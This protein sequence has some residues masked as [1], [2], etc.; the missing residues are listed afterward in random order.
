M[1]AAA[2]LGILPPIVLPPILPPPAP[3]NA[4]GHRH[5][6]RHH[7]RSHHHHRAR[8]RIV[9]TGRR[10]E[11]IH[12]IPIT[13]RA[14]AAKRVAMSLRLPAGRPGRGVRAAGEVQVSTTCPPVRLPTCIGQPYDYNPV[15]TGRLVLAPNAH[16]ATGRSVAR[17]RV[18]CHQRAPNRNHHCVLAFAPRAF[19]LSGGRPRYVNL[20]IAAHNRHARARQLLV[21]GA[22]KP[23]GR[24]DQGQSRLGAIVLPRN[25]V[26]ATHLRSR[27]PE[28]RRLT[29][30]RVAHDRARV[31][32][33]IRVPHPQAGD[34]LLAKGTARLGIGRLSYNV[35]LRSRLTLATSP[36]AIAPGRAIAHHAILGGELA[37][38][39]GFNVTHGKSGYRT[40]SRATKAGVTALRGVPRTRSGHRRPLYVNFVSW[41]KPLL[42]RPD[43]GDAVR[44][45]GGGSLRAV[46]YR[47]R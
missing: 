32:Y 6:H 20:V 18:A 9:T 21:I 3:P 12:K 43:A 7:R 40:P 41:A 23:S 28:R 27:A 5:Q 10:S 34:R 24:I 14:G 1:L 33:S 19:A 15:V 46:R 25:G 39:N 35:Y 38:S 29:T 11:R 2:T 8:V 37:P 4:P 13:R 30:G 17:R 31:L 36:H 22:D 45:L 47:A 42:V 26:R 16:S 44:L